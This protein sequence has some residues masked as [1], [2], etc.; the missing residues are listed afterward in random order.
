MTK[1]ANVTKAS[2]KG[3]ASAAKVSP[4]PPV[5]AKKSCGSSARK[6]ARGAMAIEDVVDVDVTRLPVR[7]QLFVSEFVECG[8]GTQAAIRSG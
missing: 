6:I 8:N 4:R 1:P 5:I 2:G 7:L 3:G